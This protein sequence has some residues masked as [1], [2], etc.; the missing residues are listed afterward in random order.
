MNQRPN[1]LLLFSDQHRGDWMPYDAEVKKRQGTEDLVLNMPNIRG[2]M[3]RG[4][5]FTRAVSPAPVCAPA[6]ACLASGRRYRNCRV[7]QNNIN[8]DTALPSFYG[9]LRESGYY[10]SGIGKFDLNKGDLDWGDGFHDAMKR[11]GFSDA[12]DSEGKMDAVWAG[13]LGHPGPYGRILQEAG[14]FQ[15]YMDDMMTRGHSTR[16]APIPSELYADNWIGQRAC[17]MIEQAPKDQ[18]WFIQVNFSGPHDPWDVTE[19]MKR[20]AEGR[21]FPDAKDC[22]ITEQNGQVRGNYGVMIENIDRL[23]GECIQAL[24]RSRTR[25][26]TIIVYSSDHGEMMGDH[27]LYGKS[28]PDQGAVHIPMVIDASCLGGKGGLYNDTPVEL[29][30]L[31]ATFLDYASV[32]ATAKLE[33]ESLRPIVEQRTE[34]VREYAISELILKDKANPF[35]AFGMIT[36]GTWKLIM[37]N[38][39]PDRLYRIG[40][41]PFEMNDV[42]DKYPDVVQKLRSDFASRGQKPNPVMEAYKKSFRTQAE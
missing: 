39:V 15:A 11:I 9:M 23:T 17:H 6:R 14:C 1:I 24:E 33:S 22:T 16:P 3:E 4:T 18:P 42:A 8:Y 5:T 28:K 40:E 30:D 31:A 35:D 38:R 19:E 21:F 2:L 32:K 13:M 20:A 7:Y 10:V 36:D 41:D 37:K 27:N 25:D 34:R 29:Q 12:A 26:N